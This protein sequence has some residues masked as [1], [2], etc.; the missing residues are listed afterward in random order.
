MK[1][2]PERTTKE[3]K[4]MINDF[5]Y[6]EIQRQNNICINVFCYEI[7]LTYSVYLSDQKFQNPMDLILKTDENKF[8]YVYIKDFNRFM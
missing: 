6:D 8:H 2:H 1:I 4:N 5:D 3:D 7:N